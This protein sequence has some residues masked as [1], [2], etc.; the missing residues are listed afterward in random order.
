MGLSDYFFPK[1]CVNCKK[2]G[3]YLCENCFTF[4][5]FDV[6]NTCLICGKLSF[7]GLTHKKCLKKYSIDGSFSAVSYNPIAKKLLNNF[8]NK[9]YIS[10]L[11]Y[12]ISELFY[13]SIIQNEPFSREIRNK[14][15]ALVPVSLPKAIAKK[16]G[17]NQ[18]ELITKELSK[19]FKFSKSS[20]NIFLIDD[21]VKTGKTLKKEAAILKEEGAQRVIGLTFAKG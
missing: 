1:R 19:K 10:D 5:S 14:S 9:P 2:G 6:K 12:L 7:D 20:K 8:K 11:K 4:V 13:E 21:L 3:S 15:W 18:S 17:Y 16:R